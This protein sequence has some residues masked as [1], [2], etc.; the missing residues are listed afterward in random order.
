[1]APAVLIDFWRTDVS[2]AMNLLR[3]GEPF[4]GMTMFGD[5]PIYSPLTLDRYTDDPGFNASVKTIAK[6]GIP[7]LP[8]HIPTL[9]EMRSFPDGG[10]EFAAHGV[11]PRRGKSLVADLEGALNE[12]FVH[13]YRSYPA[14]YKSDPVQLVYSEADSHPNKLGVQAM[15]EALERML[16]EH[17]ATSK[18]LLHTN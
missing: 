17:P 4:H 3:H 15:A 2:F 12:P 11:P 16:L 8:V 9:P 14:T 6:T 1:V 10:Y 7:L 18:L 13:L 5:Q